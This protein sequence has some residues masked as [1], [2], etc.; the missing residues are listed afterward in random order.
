MFDARDFLTL[1][2]APRPSDMTVG[3]RAGAAVRQ[4]DFMSRVRGW[5]AT[6]QQA[7][8][9]DF[10]LCFADSI[11]FA[12]ALFGAWHA[13]KTAYLPSD[14]L[15]VTCAALRHTVHGFVGEFPSDCSPIA[16]QP[17][18]L[19]LPAT[20]FDAL[21]PDFA[22]LV[23]YTSGSTGAPQAIPKKLSQI[24]SEVA[25]LEALFGG[26]AGTAD[27]VA[28]VSHQHIYGLLFKVL[29]PLAAAR[30]IYARSLVFPEELA[31][32]CA[33]QDCILVSSPAHLKRLPESPVWAAAAHRIRAVF[34]SGGPLPLDVVRAT[35]ALLAH[36]PIEVYGSSETGGVAWRQRFSGADES[37]AVLPGVDWRIDPD[38]EVLA[39][40]S[41]HLPD[42]NWFRTADRA[43]PAGANRFLL[44]GRVD[45]I[46]KLEEKRI[47]LDLIEAQL[48]RSALVAES[49]ILL[50]G[51]RRDKLVAFVVPST[52]GRHTLTASGKHVLNSLLREH[53]A[54]AVERIALPRS[55]RY[56]DAL[57]V[58]A[59]GKTTHA[60]LH[61]LLEDSISEA[62][63]LPRRRLLE[64]D[65]QRVLFELVAP[66]D[67]LYFDGH[68]TGAPVLPGVVQV[69]WAVALGREFF[70]LP[71]VFRAI[72]ALKFQQVIRPDT[73]FSAELLYDPLKSSLAFRYYSA[74]GAH[75]SGRLMFG[76]ADV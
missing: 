63:I 66:A 23:V 28:T 46:V 36:V 13:G 52:E 70:D 17:A 3:W 30:P 37:W 27:V 42:A 50:V 15:P 47:S 62:N 43:Q 69:E 68:F 53:L 10:A 56:L 73:A 60:E 33:A 5:Q 19:A 16:W 34:S 71:P 4:H 18:A 49:R 41:P 67:L 72:H 51:G 58:N 40:R 64:H 38:D 76:V 44:G 7:P 48:A 26:I 8:G 29:W 25:T 35:E 1:L 57:P 31:Q 39:L 65:A 2:R 22:G 9:R 24:A 21:D 45:R 55:W 6:L 32:A 54:P 11:E 59:Q 20:E 61:A 75:A 12:A 14:A 74:A